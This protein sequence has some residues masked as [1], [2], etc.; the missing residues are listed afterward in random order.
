MKIALICPS[1]I[2]YMPYVSNYEKILKE[3]NVDYDIINWDRFHIE[4]VNQHLKYRDFR[5]GHQRNYLD[6]C[7]Y[8]RFILKRLDSRY[9]KVV[10]FGI[11]LAYFLR[12]VLL[13]KYKNKYIIDIRDHNK[14]VRFFNIKKII[15]NSMFTVISSPGYKEWLPRSEQYVIN[16]NTQVECL[17]NLNE[18]DINS[19][20]RKIN[21]A[22]IGAIRDFNINIDFIKSLKNNEEI[23]L[24]FH[25][26]GDIN[27]DIDVS[28]RENNVNNVFLT[29]RYKKEDEEYLYKSSDLINV[30]RYNDGINN[31]TALPNRLYNAVLYGK[32]MLAFQGTYLADLI[33]KYKLGV[34]LDSF[35]NINI[36]VNSYFK[37][38]DIKEYQSK[39][40]SF[41]KMVIEE[42]KVFSNK[43]IDFLS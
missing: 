1:N 16:H 4:D 9:D 42:N 3:N 33:E 37:E 10:V 12:G 28:L 31:K 40:Y 5:I 22:Y 24:Y 27:E 8:K 7:K 26:E 38:F 23:N 39:R 21:I 15:D 29:G 32:P 13:K 35:E 20:N 34:V 25:G 36:R 19:Y 14:I 43:M 17:D 30:L 2:L 6:Y 11:Q 41:L 18:L